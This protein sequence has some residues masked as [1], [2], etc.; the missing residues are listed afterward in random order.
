[1]L[2]RLMEEK[3]YFPCKRLADIIVK[4]IYLPIENSTS[5]AKSDPKNPITMY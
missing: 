3:K 4:Y 5:A 1:M 2:S